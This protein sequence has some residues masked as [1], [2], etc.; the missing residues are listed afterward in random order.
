MVNKASAA[1]WASR[2]SKA[3]ICAAAFA[4]AMG[5]LAATGAH[6]DSASSGGI[7]ESLTAKAKWQYQAPPGSNPFTK[8]LLSFSLDKTVSST[9][10]VGGN[11]VS[12][13]TEVETSY[14]V[15]STLTGDFHFLQNIEC[16][17]NCDT[18]VLVTLTDLVKNT[19]GSAVNLRFDSQIT[20]GHLG[21]QGTDPGGS[22]MFDFSVTQK[23]A[24]TGGLTQTL[25]NAT[26]AMGTNNPGSVSPLNG[27]SHY[28]NGNEYAFDW[29]ATNINVNLLAINPGETATIVYTSLLKI[30]TRGLCTDLTVCEAA[31]VVFGDPR[32][33]G[34]TDVVG[35][36]S[37]GFGAFSLFSTTAP[38]YVVGAN[39]GQMDSYAHIVSQD[40]GLPPPP[41][42]PPPPV[43]YTPGPFAAAAVPEPATWAMLLLGFGAIGAAAR[44]RS[45]LLRTA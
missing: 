33:S 25:Y 21:F 34:S 35:I 31:Q 16:T 12:L 32:S 44:R 27:L 11:P 42:P 22:A 7:T 8:E 24:A 14:D 17:G 19:T 13:L 3:R 1:G 45:A 29:G 5:L 39:Y 26:G 43:T 41:P 10:V 30:S 2:S 4:T 37:L 40:A 20:P 36:D 18:M 9:G 28:V 38:N 23:S 15:Q 6:A